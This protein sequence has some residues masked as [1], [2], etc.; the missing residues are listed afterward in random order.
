MQ[1]AKASSALWAI[2]AALTLAAN[3][4][5]QN[6]APSAQPSQAQAAS[7]A[8]T[9]GQPQAATPS[10]QP[11]AAAT[12]PAATSAKPST[13]APAPQ[14]ENLGQEMEKGAMWPVREAEKGVRAVENTVDP[15]SKAKLVPES[16]AR[17]TALKAVPGTVTKFELEKKHG[18]PVYEFKIKPQ[19]GKGLKE[20]HVDAKTGAL[21]NVKKD[22]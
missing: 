22:D 6:Q 17:Q 20:V 15:D 12:S 11:P 10:A 1:T 2:A 16:Q 5:A 9:T 4:G 13:A 19:S 8:P 7:P 21:M 18:K 3:A 14:K